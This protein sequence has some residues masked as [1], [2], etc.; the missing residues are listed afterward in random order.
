VDRGDRSGRGSGDD[1]SDP[2]SSDGGGDRSGRVSGDGDFG[3]DLEDD[4][5]ESGEDWECGAGALVPG[6]VVHEAELELGI[7]GP[8]FTRIELVE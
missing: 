7:G 6:A 4:V 1:R 3:D 8:V 5:G 2:G